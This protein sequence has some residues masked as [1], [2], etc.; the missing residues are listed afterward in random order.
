MHDS[1]IST[2]KNNTFSEEHD[3]SCTSSKQKKDCYYKEVK[4][5]LDIHGLIKVRNSYPNNPIIGYLNIKTLQNKIISLGEIV[6]KAPLNVFCIDETKLD[7]SFSN[8]QFI[9]ESFQFPPFRRD[10]NSKGGGKLV[11]VKQG[12]IAK[13]LENLETKFSETIC[14]ELTIS[15][16]KWC[17]LF[18]YRP[19][20]QNKTLFFEEISSSLSYIVNKYDNYIIAGDLN[21]NMLDP[22]CDESS[23]FFDL[24]DAYN[25][26]NLVK[27]A[28][29]FKSS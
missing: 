26:S 24:K 21:I 22:K 28:T 10:R 15:K 4:I 8:S 19:P 25:L 16:K 29:C 3:L 2:T 7:H 5:K 9:L 6:A 11:Y 17:A 1:R 14:I 13:R 20:K 27:S 23:H 12:I 18:A